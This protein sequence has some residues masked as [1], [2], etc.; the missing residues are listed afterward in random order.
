MSLILILWL[1]F[2]EFVCTWPGITLIYV[3]QYSHSFS[4]IRLTVAYLFLSR[5]SLG[6]VPA[7][8]CFKVLM[9]FLLALSILKRTI[10]VWFN[11]LLKPSMI[12]F[13]CHFDVADGDWAGILRVQCDRF[14]PV[15]ARA[16]RAPDECVRRR[17][18]LIIPSDRQQPRDAAAS[19]LWVQQR[20]S[21]RYRRKRKEKKKERERGSEAGFLRRATLLRIGLIAET[22][23]L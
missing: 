19:R 11:I 23:Y 2:K 18:S 12:W 3:L 9:C 5:S 14:P 22:L 17:A 4:L 6:N 21:V 20:L 1:W 16:S 15:I 7:A 13:W 10:N 8:W